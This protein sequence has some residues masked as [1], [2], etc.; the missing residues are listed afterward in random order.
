MAAG[1]LGSLPFLN[2]HPRGF[3][4]SVYVQPKSARNMMVGCHGDSLKIKLTAP[5]VDG[6]ANKMCVAF[7]AKQLRLAKSDI[8][9]VSGHT[10]RTK[11]LEIKV[12]S[13]ETKKKVVQRLENYGLKGNSP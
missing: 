12:D 11:R 2:E 7:L 8:E 13:R 1:N 5:P 4:L 3:V 10:G 6:A 9:I